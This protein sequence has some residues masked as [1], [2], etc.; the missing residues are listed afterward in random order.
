MARVPLTGGAYASSAL[1]ASAQVCKNLYPE[2]IPREEGEPAPV[3]HLLTPGLTEL[4]QLSSA[5]RVRGIYRATNGRV[6]L[7]IG[8]GLFWLG[9]DWATAR[10][11]SIT[12]G[13][14]PVSMS[15]NGVD[16]CVVDGS[17]N[18]WFVDLATNISAQIDDEAFYGADRVDYIS[19]SFVF[20][21]PGT[22]QFYLGDSIART[23]DPLY[24][25][26]KAGRQDVLVSFAV[27]SGFLWLL[28]QDT[29]EIWVYSGAPDF[30]LQAVPGATVEQGC[31]AAH[32]IGRA[33]KSIFWLSRSKDGVGIVLQGSGYDAKR[34]STHALETEITGYASR[35]DARG[36]TYQIGG[37]TFYVLAF[38][39][40]T[41]AYDL[42]TMHWHQWTWLDVNG[43]E[44][45]HRASCMTF[46]YD[47]VLV[48]DRENGKV[49]AAD[50]NVF[51]DAGNPIRRVRSFPHSSG[52]GKRVRYTRFTADMQVGDVP[53]TPSGAPPEVSLR[54]SDDR[55]ASWSNPVKQSFG[56][57]GQY[58]TIPTW[59]RLG[60]AR[61]RVWELSWSA[62]M[63]T[64]LNGAFVT[65]ESAAT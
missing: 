13:D 30:P 1:I 61:D 8:D 27:V 37:H 59:N 54:W 48:G 65:G 12:S 18:G 55:G 21:R 20:N 36:M 52:K 47:R 19:T 4:T 16:L 56:A 44:Q 10:I 23:F 3:T 15:D 35:R 64:A 46:G 22:R 58:L 11:V 50:S 38:E 34:I 32:S 6:F 26:D 25:S 51:T 40:A 5:S 14:T 2:S 29:S 28:G 63:H 57:T 31:E 41:W 62:P 60:I 24:V 42:A 49:Y 45:P 17:A 9:A 53:V 39:E 43:V 7:A 33:D